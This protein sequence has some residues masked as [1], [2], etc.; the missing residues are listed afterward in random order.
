MKKFVTVSTI[1]IGLIVAGIILTQLGEWP[2][3]S[4]DNA[5]A[6]YD[7]YGEAYATGLLVL[8]VAVILVLSAG[9]GALVSTV[10]YLIGWLGVLVWTFCYQYIWNGN[11]AQ[12]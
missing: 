5:F 6:C 12:I 2:I 8:V 11:K 7:P 10:L 1:L 3:P 9:I 4:L